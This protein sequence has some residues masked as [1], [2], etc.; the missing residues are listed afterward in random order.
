MR[1]RTEQI[2]RNI[3]NALPESHR[4][5]VR[6]APRIV[7]YITAARQIGN[8]RGIV[9]DFYKITAIIERRRTKACHTRGNRD[10]R[11][12]ATIAERRRTD[13]RHR[14]GTVYAVVIS[15]WYDDF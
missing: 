9:V 4:D 7:E 1:I 5:P 6:I 11:K 8:R 10:L 12:T 2:G 15:R 13:T 3:F 14:R